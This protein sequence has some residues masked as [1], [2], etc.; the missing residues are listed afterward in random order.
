M[1][2]WV[3]IAEC[4]DFIDSTTAD[5][6][7]TNNEA[8]ALNSEGLL[9]V[10]SVNHS[11]KP[12]HSSERP[13]HQSPPRISSSVR[14]LQASEV[15]V[16][17]VGNQN[18]SV[19]HDFGNVIPSDPTLQLA[20]RLGQYLQFAKNSQLRYYGATSNL[21][22]ISDG[23]LPLFEPSIR[24]IRAQGATALHQAGLAKA[25]SADYEKHLTS[26][27]FSWHNSLLGEVN[28]EIYFSQKEMYESGDDSVYY[29]PTLANAMYVTNRPLV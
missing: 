21:N 4:P 27:Y 14:T 19:N 6:A 8:S 2:Y 25:G 28:K 26:L 24:T 3:K 7:T 5:A 17:R 12:Q 16:N 1:D 18:G 15:H 10:Q 9:G 11:D 22:F 20:S 29:S 13:F 23:L